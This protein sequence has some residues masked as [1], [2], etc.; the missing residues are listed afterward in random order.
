MKNTIGNTDVLIVVDVQNDFLP[1]GAL[2]VQDS[3]QI[4]PVING[5]NAKFQNV[6]LTQDW[7]PADHISFASNN[8]GTSINQEISV[9]YGTQILWP[10]HCVQNTYGAALSSE[11]DV[12]HARLILRKGMNPKV[13]SY[14][15]FLEADRKT[16]TGLAGYLHEIGATTLYIA[17]LATDFCVFWS[18]MDAINDGFNVFVIE[19]ATRGI[20]VNGSLD[21]AWKTMTQAGVQRI[22]SCKLH[23]MSHTFNKLFAQPTPSLENARNPLS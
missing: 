21:A 2:A 17:G 5:L 10:N 1:G 19:D 4:I 18:A 14:S 22:T 23:A 15:A 8:P 16:R 20:N 9:N 11:L 12:P 3:E 7:H 13:D 6:V